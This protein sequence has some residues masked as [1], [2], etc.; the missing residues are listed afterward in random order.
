LQSYLD[1]YH[2]VTY[3][4]DYNRPWV[5]IIRHP[6]QTFV[7]KLGEPFITTSCNVAWK[8][9]VDDIKK[10]PSDI[11]EGVDYIIDPATRDSR[12]GA[13]LGWWKPSV[14]I[15]FVADKIIER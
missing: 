2:G 7:E 5:R 12:A 15:D 1:T 9:V 11:T 4:F 13:W 6:F 14:L 8:A 3:I 10:I